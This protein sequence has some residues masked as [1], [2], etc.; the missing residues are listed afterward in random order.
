MDLFYGTSFG[1]SVSNTMH[2]VLSTSSNR[3]CREDFR[4][5]A[6]CPRPPYE[7]P[8]ERENQAKRK[9]SLVKRR[10]LLYSGKS[11]YQSR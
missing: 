1:Y 11:L 9:Q 8:E 2:N 7:P 10:R 6:A 3:L 5:G 4:R